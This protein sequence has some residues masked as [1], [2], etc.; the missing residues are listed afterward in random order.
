MHGIVF[1]FLGR[2]RFIVLGIHAGCTVIL[3]C[4]PTLMFYLPFILLLARPEIEAPLPSASM[5]GSWHVQRRSLHPRFVDRGWA[6]ACSAFVP[7]TAS[8]LF[9][10]FPQQSTRKAPLHSTQR[11]SSASEPLGEQAGEDR[12]MGA[13]SWLAS[14]VA[15]TSLALGYLKHK[16]VVQCALWAAPPV[17]TGQAC[18][19]GIRP[20]DLSRELVFNH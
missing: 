13:I 3:D 14:Q 11:V 18:I 10:Y 2:K 15:I 9:S 17:P 16:G 20:C 4:L 19:A 12:G 8:A 6:V 1:K 5:H 7:R